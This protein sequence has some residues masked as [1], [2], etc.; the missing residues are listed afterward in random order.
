MRHAVLLSI[1][2]VVLSHGSITTP[3][4]RN[5]PSVEGGWCPWCQG[6]INWC[7]PN[8]TQHCQP[9][10]PCWGAVYNTHV[11]YEKFGKYKN[12]TAPDGTPWV[13]ASTDKPV[14]CPGKRVDFKYYINA[15][16]NGVYRWE[17]QPFDGTPVTEKGFNNF[18]SWR[19]VNNDPDT[20]FYAED[21]RTPL[22][23]GNCISGH[24]GPWTPEHSHC[25][26]NIF[27]ETSMELPAGMKPG[28]TT[29]RWFWYG[30][31]TTSGERVKGPEHSL[32]V[33][34]V[35]IDVGTPEQCA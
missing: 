32:F 4:M 31:M 15:D 13:Q 33:N 29:M 21:G 10:T 12:L 17:A 16:H 3:T 7:D 18:T 5:N 19:S 9:P 24:G 2:P 28:P 1:L 14:W 20:K 6:A 8:A 25:R 11:P 35:D 26:D 34:C 23:P 30:A 22:E 27:A